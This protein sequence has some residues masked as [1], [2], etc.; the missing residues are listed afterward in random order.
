MTVNMEVK[1]SSLPPLISTFSTFS[2]SRDGA[3]LPCTTQP[4]TFFM[5]SKGIS[6]FAANF[7][8]DKISTKVMSREILMTLQPSDETKDA[9]FSAQKNRRIDEQK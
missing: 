7:L 1:L 3:I 6:N 4:E 8:A 2:E 5:F 9:T